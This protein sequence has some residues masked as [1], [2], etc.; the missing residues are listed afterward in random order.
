[1]TT[2]RG[3]KNEDVILP[4]VIRAVQPDMKVIV[5]L[6]DPVD[7]MY[8]AYWYYG[9][10]YN[11]YEPWGMSDAGFDKWAKASALCLG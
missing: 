11:I 7:R 8:S 2:C 1:M 4:A 6:R 9:C 3:K 10:L 5:M